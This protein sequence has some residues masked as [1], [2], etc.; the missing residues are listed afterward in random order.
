[1]AAKRQITIRLSTK[2]ADFL[3]AETRLKAFCGGQGAGK[4]FVGSYD[5]LQRVQPG[6]LYEI[7]AP[8][9]PMLRDATFRSFRSVAEMTHQLHDFKSTEFVATVQTR[10]GGTAE[11][12]FRSADGPDKLR[13]PNLSGVWI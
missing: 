11:V 5:L 7:V 1:M 6:R 4:S 8:T 9:F 10:Q 13:G 12:L 3:A 2:Q